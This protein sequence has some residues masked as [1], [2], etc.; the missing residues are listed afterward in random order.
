MVDMGRRTSMAVERLS[1]QN[2]DQHGE[3]SGAG[4]LRHRLAPDLG[5]A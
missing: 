4:D 5:M 2:L 1:T 3:H